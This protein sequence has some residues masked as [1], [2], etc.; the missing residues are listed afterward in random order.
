MKFQ[1][2][3]TKVQDIKPI[4]AGVYVVK[5]LEID[6]TKKSR[7]GNAKMVIKTEI[8]APQ[9]VAATQRNWW[10]SLSLVESALFRL[11][12]LMEATEIPVRPTGFDT[13]DLIGR[14][15]GVIVTEEETKEY[16]KRNQIVNFLKAKETKPEVKPVAG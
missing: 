4:P 5:L 2:D 15:V 3:L 1:I 10:F 13:A 16:G 7:T 8:L 11:K 9:T 14:E 12:Q 6:A